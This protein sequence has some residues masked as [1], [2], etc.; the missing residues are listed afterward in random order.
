MDDI[1]QISAEQAKEMLAGKAILIDV[2]EPIEIAAERIPGAIE[3]PLSELAKGAV[4]EVAPD[5]TPIFF[6][7]SGNR[8]RVY[9]PALA[10]AAGK[11]AYAIDGGIIE[12]KQAGFETET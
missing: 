6:C 10:D 11:P 3:L 2:R 5:Q 8:T 4:L 9:A 12:W 1:T 7:R